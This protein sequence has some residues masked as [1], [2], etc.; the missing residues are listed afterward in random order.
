[1]RASLA[2]NNPNQI[3]DPVFG[4]LGN[5]AAAA[6]QGKITSTDCLQQATADQAFTNAKAKGDVAGMTAA[7]CFSPV[8]T[9]SMPDSLSSWCTVP[10][11][12]TQARSAWPR[13]HALRSRQSTPR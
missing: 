1:V 11:N 3:S 6:G 10:S 2:L 5:A 9:A 13:L 4:L 12:V 8:S 7:V